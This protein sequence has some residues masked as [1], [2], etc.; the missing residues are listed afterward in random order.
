MADSTAKLINTLW[1]HPMTRVEK[2]E[3]YNTIPRPANVESFHKT[4]MNPEIE[5]TLPTRVKDNDTALAA[6]QW[7]IQFG[8]RP[9]ATTLDGI[10][11]GK[12]VDAKELVTA[13]V[14]TLKILAHT[15]NTLM[16]M[17]RDNVRPTL[18]HQ[19]KPLAK[20]D[21]RQ[22]FKYVLGEYLNAQA[23]S[24]E[25]DRKMANMIV[26]AL[27]RHHP[28]NFERRQGNNRGGQERS[29]P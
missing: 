27:G 24:L 25:A 1:A 7:G 23:T 4:R 6:A 20:K 8:A 26:K 28:K 18:M 16:G 2:T 5:S 17:R 11:T 13:L 19:L 9:I 15:S 10:E 21:G 14:T 3:L 12:A 22:G 29:R